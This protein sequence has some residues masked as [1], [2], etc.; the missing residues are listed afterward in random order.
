MQISIYDVIAKLG[1][2]Q[3]GTPNKPSQ[4]WLMTITIDPDYS[5]ESIYLSR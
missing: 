5:E 2:N 4:I 3:L 1:F